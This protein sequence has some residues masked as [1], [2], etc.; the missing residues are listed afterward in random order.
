MIRRWHVEPDIE[1]PTADG[2]VLACSRQALELA[3]ADAVAMADRA[4][5][6]FSMWLERYPTGLPGEM[7]TTGAIVEWRDRTDAKA[8][9]E[10]QTGQARVVEEEPAPREAVEEMQRVLD[11]PEVPPQDDPT[12]YKGGEFHDDVGDGLDPNTLEEEDETALEE[13]G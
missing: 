2:Y 6:G 12:Q 5:G 10:K 1:V 13:V 8:A 4:G 11:I 3:V 9:P 7:V